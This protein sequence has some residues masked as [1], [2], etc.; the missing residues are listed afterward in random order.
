MT[1]E[2][3]DLN[4]GREFATYDLLDEVA[5]QYNL[6]RREAHDS[7]HAFLTQI[8]EIDGDKVIL[9]KNAARPEL[10]THN[11]HNLDIRYW[12]T[13]SDETADSIREAFA[14]VYASEDA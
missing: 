9:A 1:T 13:I 12:L 2:I 11:P 3:Y 10:L 4:P 8:I 14:A 6:D 5:E 7:I